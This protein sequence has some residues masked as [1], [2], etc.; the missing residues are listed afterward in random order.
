MA[1]VLYHFTCLYHLSSIMAEKQL[2]TTCSNLRPDNT[3]TRPVVWLTT[4]AEPDLEG[5]ALY[6]VMDK[7]EV[8]IT[9]KR[10]PHFKYWLTWSRKHKIPTWW[11]RALEKGHKPETW[12]VSERSIT[13]E[14]ILK[15]EN[16]KTG[17]VYYEYS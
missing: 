8:K 17:E 9:I 15:I 11:A 4:N 16:T 1:K 5:N 6:S 13:F 14:D 3:F 7:T 2:R 12:W 10:L